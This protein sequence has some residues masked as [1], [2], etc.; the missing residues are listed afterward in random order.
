M[1]D[2]DRLFILMTRRQ[3]LDR[4]R[5]MRHREER[6]EKQKAYYRENRERC[7]QKVKEC[8]KRREEY[9]YMTL[10]TKKL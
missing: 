1:T 10:M 6:L 7:I 9:L 8:Q 4:D 2:L 5:Y 3:Q